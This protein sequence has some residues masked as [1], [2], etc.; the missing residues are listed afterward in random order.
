MFYGNY[1]L[2]GD[3]EEKKRKKKGRATA[4]EDES[5][6]NKKKQKTGIESYYLLLNSRR[7]IHKYKNKL[8][9]SQ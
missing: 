4:S 3:A 1:M 8:K 6:T 5:K 7:K 2:Q 9:I